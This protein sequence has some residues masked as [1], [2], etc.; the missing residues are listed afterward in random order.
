MTMYTVRDREGTDFDIEADSFDD[1]GGYLTLMRGNK[2]IA[3]FAAGSWQL[4]IASQEGDKA[5][6]LIPFLREANGKTV[7]QLLDEILRDIEFLEGEG[8]DASP[9]VLRSYYHWVTDTLNAQKC[10]D[11]Q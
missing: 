4:I 6:V 10:E 5:I 9:W 11:A 2:V 8:G 3:E 1:L 7:P